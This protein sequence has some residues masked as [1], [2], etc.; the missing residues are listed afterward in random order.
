[1]AR[2]R[3]DGLPKYLE[4]HPITRAY[5][6]KSPSMAAKANLSSDRTVAIRLAKSLNSRYRLQIEQQ[7]MRIEAF[8]DFGSIPFGTA[9]D[10][11]VSKYIDDYRLKSSTTR[12]LRQHQQRLTEQLGGI[13]V[14]A[15]QD[16][17]V[18]TDPDMTRACQK[19]HARKVLRADMMLPWSVEDDDRDGVREELPA[20]VLRCTSRLRENSLRIL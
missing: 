13:Q 8:I 12:L 4:C 9:F 18:H 14:P 2:A 7:A 17:M 15:V 20:Y 1:M 19:G 3:R 16:L 6:F 5:Y 10:A 11:F